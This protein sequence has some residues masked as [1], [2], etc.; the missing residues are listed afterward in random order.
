MLDLSKMSQQEYAEYLVTHNDKPNL[1]V[2]DLLT[3]RPEYRRYSS[4]ER[5]DLYMSK[6]AETKDFTK[7][8]ENLWL[9][10][11]KNKE[12]G[13]E[14]IGAS[15]GWTNFL[16]G[17][18]S[19]IKG[20]TRYKSYTTLT[21]PLSITNEEYT[22][23]LKGL[24]GSGYNGQVKFP[25]IGSRALLSFDNIVMHGST[26]ADAKLGESFSKSFFGHRIAGTQFGV[27]GEGKS[28]TQ[29]LSDWVVSERKKLTNPIDTPLNML[30]KSSSFR[31][32]VSVL[33]NRYTN[34]INELYAEGLFTDI[35]N[36]SD[37]A[38]RL[39][40][41]ESLERIKNDY[42]SR[43]PKPSNEKT[44]Q[45][46]VS[47]PTHNNTVKLEQQSQ[48]SSTNVPTSNNNR[49]NNNVK[50][51]FN[52]R[53]TSFDTETTGLNTTNP[54]L[55]KRDRIWQVGFAIDG[56]SG[57]EEHTSPFFISNSKGDL[58]P[59]NKVSRP[60]LESMLK[61]SNGKFS[62]LAFEQ[63]NFNTFMNL[64][65]KNNLLSLEDSLSKTIGQVN[66]SDVI[67]LQNMNFENKMLQSS[68]EQGLITRDYYNKLADKMNTVDINKDG[69]VNTLFQRPSEVQR[70]MR[71]ADMLYHTEY[72][73]NLSEDSFQ[74]YRETVNKAI[75]DYATVINDPKRQGAV[76]V[77]LQDLSKAFLANAANRG[78]IEKQTATLGLNVDFLS[79]AILGTPE[80]HTALQDSEDTISLFKKMWSMNSELN[81]TSELSEDTLK[82]ISNI[83]Q[84][85]PEEINKRFLS[86][87]RSVLDDFKTKNYT[88][89]GDNFSWYNPEVILKEKSQSGTTNIILD[90]I[91]TTSKRNETSLQSALNNVIKRYTRYE[92]NINGLNREAYTNNIVESFNTG[93]DYNT[94]HKKVDSDYF[95]LKSD[96]STS[97]TN[98]NIIS[99]NNQIEKQ[100]GSAW[101]DSVSFLG[102]D[103]KRKTR[104]GIIG[105]IGAVLAYM[106]ITPK[107][108][109]LPNP[110]SNVSEQF[111]DE[112]YLGT[113]FVDFNERNKHYMM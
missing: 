39:W 85:Q 86:T 63:G 59:S 94:L 60:F 71:K 80:K 52:S 76:A 89:I 43:Q 21:E 78:L 31:P 111:Y 26:E 105:S 27:D 16:I 15:S 66:T 65:E 62:Q 53:L 3:D 103:M 41:G 49:E 67:V 22:N 88:K 83:K 96:L 36:S 32:K 110:N 64:Y 18:D 77:E 8:M 10:L 57:V 95:S 19:H 25:G 108:A 1:S 40:D 5:V 79:R 45:T 84:Q 92:N 51:F 102:K 6:R 73:N 24:A 34:E 98:Q 38:T 104:A 61:N 68:L 44:T 37:I 55:S 106:A 90:E 29:L 17:K 11:S 56:A 7:Q 48:S 109:P 112:Q 93:I 87:V 35:S 13:I 97:N 70:S 28:H 101:D 42:K 2:Y 47:K 113:A 58:E 4:Q 81:S 20:T 107:P 14:A 74:K 75:S 12:K 30:G 99:K 54:N 46:V 91:S 50:N 72:L 33:K 82:V 100:V 69:S 9:E 23:F